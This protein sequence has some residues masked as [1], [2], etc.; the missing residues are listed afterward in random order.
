VYGGV[1]GLLAF[2]TVLTRGLIHGG[3]AE[4]TLWRA[5]VC[6]MVFGLVGHIV[7]RV[8]AWIVEDS[9]R[10]TI[11]AELAMRQHPDASRAVPG[12]VR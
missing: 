9:V 8:A 7:G 3:G 10:A 1:L 6:L 11:A 2:L 5:M 4:T 12:A